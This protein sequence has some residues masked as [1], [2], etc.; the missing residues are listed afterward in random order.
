MSRVCCNY[1]VYRCRGTTVTTGCTEI[2]EVHSNY[3]MCRDRGKY[4]KYRVYRDRGKYS[5]Y[6]VY[7]DMGSAQ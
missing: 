5:N 1:R 6:G 3:R 7:R 4:S 2:W